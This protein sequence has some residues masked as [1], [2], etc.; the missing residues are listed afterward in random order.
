MDLGFIFAITGKF[1][2]WNGL[3]DL[4]IIVR[5]F[6]FVFGTFFLPWPGAFGSAF[7]VNP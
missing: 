7:G 4:L 3:S 6:T 1:N 5:L 2:A